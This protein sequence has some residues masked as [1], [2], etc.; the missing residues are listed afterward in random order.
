MEV[1][2]NQEFLMLS[3]EEVGKLLASEDLNIPSEEM[4]FNVSSKHSTLTAKFSNNT[5]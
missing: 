1:I 5:L 4:I 2:R 3:A